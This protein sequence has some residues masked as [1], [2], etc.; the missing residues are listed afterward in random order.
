MLVKKKDSGKLYAMKILKKKH[1]RQKKQVRNTWSERKILE[2][3]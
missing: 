3:I 2:K 1:I